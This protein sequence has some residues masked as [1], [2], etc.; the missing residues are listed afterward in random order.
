VNTG[1]AK[2]TA[3]GAYSVALTSDITTKLTAGSDKL[4]II[5]VTIPVAIPTFFTQQFVTVAP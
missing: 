2:M 4:E 1:D 5:V 3:E